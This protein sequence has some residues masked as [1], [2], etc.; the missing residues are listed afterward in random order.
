MAD[1]VLATS[2]ASAQL[3]QVNGHDDDFCLAGAVGGAPKAERN[4]ARSV[5][6]DDEIRD[7]GR[8][9]DTIRNRCFLLM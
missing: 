4:S 1:L 9:I 2:A 7:C 5:S 6:G 3:V 8:A